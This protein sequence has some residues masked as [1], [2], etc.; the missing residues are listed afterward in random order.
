M[1]KKLFLE[2]YRPTK[3][4]GIIAILL[5]L[6]KP[7][8][9]WWGIRATLPDELI[10]VTSMYRTAGDM[11]YFEIVSSVSDGNF[12]ETNLFALVET[13]ASCRYHRG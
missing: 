11:Q 8:A 3:I 12:G 2:S 13:G 9:G 4:I 5:V 1:L 7:L 6:Y 10:E